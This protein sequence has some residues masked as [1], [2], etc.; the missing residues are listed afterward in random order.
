MDEKLLDIE[1][2]YGEEN[3]E[4][5]F[6]GFDIHAFVKDLCGKILVD[7]LD[8]S[9]MTESENKAYIFG[10]H[11]TLRLLD[12]TLNNMVVDGHCIDNLFLAVHIPNLEIMTEFATVEE[13]KDKYMIKNV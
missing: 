7:N 8:N 11:D 2:E 12:Q 5:I 10:I 3:K 6:V 1:V 13:V 9:N 4:E